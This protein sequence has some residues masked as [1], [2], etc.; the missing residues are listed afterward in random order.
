[1]NELTPIN[2]VEEACK[3]DA[4][5][6]VIDIETAKDEYGQLTGFFEDARKM[7]IAYGMQA[8]INLRGDVLLV[9]LTAPLN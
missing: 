7:A 1:M 3:V 8:D 2:Q 6:T 5:H 4:L 9:R